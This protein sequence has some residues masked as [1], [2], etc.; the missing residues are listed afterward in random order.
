MASERHLPNLGILDLLF[1]P[2]G[3]IIHKADSGYVV[4]RVRVHTGEAEY[5][6]NI[7][8]R[9]WGKKA[10]REVERYGKEDLYPTGLKLQRPGH[11]LYAY[12]VK[13]PKELP[14]SQLYK[15]EREKRWI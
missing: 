2:H 8:Q 1:R 9:R 5:L 10:Q 6:C 4:R 15:E 12:L 11:Q 14:L 13:A 3:Y 7:C